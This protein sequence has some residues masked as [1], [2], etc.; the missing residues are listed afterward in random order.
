MVPCVDDR[1]GKSGCGRFIRERKAERLRRCQCYLWLTL[2]IFD[3][4]RSS[5]G[6]ISRGGESIFKLLFRAKEVEMYVFIY[7]MVLMEY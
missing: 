5:S 7:A 2:D 3:L 4:I 1:G 6:G